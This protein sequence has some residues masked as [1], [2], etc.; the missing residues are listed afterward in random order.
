[1]NIYITCSPEYSEDKLDEIVALLSSIHGE[2]KFSKGKLLTQNQYKRLNTKLEDINS[3]SG[4][5]FDEYFDIV[6]GYREIREIDDNDFVILISSIRNTRNWFSAFNRRNIF[7]HGVEWDLYSNVDSKYGIA[8]QC[9]ENI[10]QSLID[11]DITNTHTNPNIHRISIGCINDYCGFKPDIIKKLQSANICQVCYERAIAKGVNDFILSQIVNIMEEIRKEFVISKRFTK[12]VDLKT[13]R[14]DEHGR[15]TI[16]GKPIKLEIL[17]AV[18]YIG[19]LKKTSGIPNDQICANRD[20]F[21]K[22]Y[23]LIKKNPDEYAIRRMC[24]KTI[25][26]RTRTE[27][28]RPTFF[29]YRSK[30][31]EALKKELGETLT[32]FYHVNLVE[33]QHR[34]GL[35]KVNIS[36]D[37]I[38]IDVKFI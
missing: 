27:K 21:E 30:I 8:H 26:Y 9:V 1:M 36:S 35:Y 3:I 20:H 12:E 7:I 5:S 6:Q 14:I 33:T 25:E 24:C 4:L 10:F 37:K 15:V 23:K 22:I 11:L 19:F 29:T 2:L 17:P 32:N 18:M 31:K 13:V 16:G 34:Q 38:D 28:I